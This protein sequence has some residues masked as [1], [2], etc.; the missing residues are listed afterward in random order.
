MGVCFVWMREKLVIQPNKVVVKFW[1]TS[2]KK[3]ESYEDWIK[4]KSKHGWTLIK[5]W[6]LGVD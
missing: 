6:G 3:Q 1:K 2:E 4:H 5:M